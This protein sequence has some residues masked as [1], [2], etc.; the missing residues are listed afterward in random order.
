M[1]RETDRC[2]ELLSQQTTLNIIRNFNLQSK[3]TQHKF[4]QVLSITCLLTT[5][6][7]VFNSNPLHKDQSELNLL[8]FSHDF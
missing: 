6:I 2:K 4:I 8:S 3:T 7:W 5:S 1:C